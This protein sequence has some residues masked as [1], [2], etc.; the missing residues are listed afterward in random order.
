LSENFTG[1]FLFLSAVV[2]VFNFGEVDMNRMIQ[3]GFTLIELMIVV[4]II[5]ILA[6]VALPAYQDYIKAANQAKVSGNAEEMFRFVNNEMRRMQ[7]RI[8]MGTMKTKDA[9]D[10]LATIPL[11]EAMTGVVAGGAGE[12]KSPSGDAAFKP[13][14]ADTS[15]D[16]ISGAVSVVTAGTIAGGNLVV[17]VTMP[18]YPEF[19]ADGSLTPTVK[20]ITWLQI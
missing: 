18:A 12:P 10:A 17:T 3:K 8:A 16:A 4:A 6:A 1:I 15:K 7:S 14:P 19:E 13:S 20:T 2:D 11:I 9:D 5:G